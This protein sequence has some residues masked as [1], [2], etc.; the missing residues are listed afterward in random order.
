VSSCTTQ[1]QEPT[2]QTSEKSFTT[3]VRSRRLGDR[4]TVL[5]HLPPEARA[6]FAKDR[7]WCLQQARG[8]GPAC[9]ELINQLL[10]DRI[11]ERLRGAQ[12][13]LKLAETFGTARLEAACRRA[14]AHASPAYRTVQSILIDGFDQLPLEASPR[15]DPNVHGGNARCVR[16][17]KTLFDTKED[18]R[19]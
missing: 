14:L 3:G 13:V 8:I 6:F 18:T 15:D 10:G 4:G 11:V 12:G 5:D 9:A 19:H 17:A 7:Q 2:L 1:Q 16:D